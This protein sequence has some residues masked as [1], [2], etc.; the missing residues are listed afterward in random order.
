VENAVSKRATPANDPLLPSGVDVAFGDIEA[1]QARLRE[2]GGPRPPAPASIA[3][4]VAVGSRDRLGPAADA[5]MHLSATAGVRAVLIACGRERTPAV[6]VAEHA[7]LVDG[8]KPPYLNNAV[9]ALRLSSLPTLVWW[10]GGASDLLEGLASLADRLVLDVD[11]PRPVWPLVPALAERT[12]I[13]DLRWARL[14]RWR[15]MMAHFFDIPDIRAA[16]ASFN[17]LRM[18]AG[19]VHAARL[20]AG[21]LASALNRTR[22]FTVDIRPAFARRASADKP[23]MARRASADEPAFARRA[24]ADEPA[25]AARA[26]TDLPPIESIALGEGDQQLTLHLAP[27]RSCISAAAAVTG[28]A[29]ASRTVSLGDQSL[30]ALIGDELRIRSR[31]M[32]FER[33]LAALSGLQAS[34]GGQ[35][36][37]A[38]ATPRPAQ[39]R[40]EPSRRTSAQRGGK[41]QKRPRRAE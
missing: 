21:W 2:D 20:F 31:D 35:P 38:A 41:R 39:G 12:A 29:G 8:I 22:G 28:H 23:A 6:R 1:T 15:A 40:P 16:A 3:T 25:L 24:S 32:A 10:R 13:S 11:D 30:V 9:A 36:P 5:L 26:T 14:T 7:I 19:D 37:K 33:A 4:I 34:V 17:T 18:E 27:S